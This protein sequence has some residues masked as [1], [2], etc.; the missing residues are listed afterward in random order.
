MFS[1]AEIA[2]ILNRDV[3]SASARLAEARG[4]VDA[5]ITEVPGTLPHPDGQH[6]LTK[7]IIEHVTAREALARALKRNVDFTPYGIIPE[8]LKGKQPDGER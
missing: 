5:V 8:D 1:H 4:N 3:R 2:D 7:V 6:R